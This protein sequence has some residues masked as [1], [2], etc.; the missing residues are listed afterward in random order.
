[1]GVF[2]GIQLPNINEGNLDDKKERKQI[3]NYLALLDEK[4]RY[5][6]QNIDI[7]ENLSEDSQKMFFKYGEDIRN[8]IK[9]T[10]GNFSLF[11]QTING[12]S[13]A[14]Q[15]VEGNTT[16]HYIV[17]GSEQIKQADPATYDN[18]GNIIPLSERFDPNK[19]DIR[20]S[21]RESGLDNIEKKYADKTDYLFLHESGDTVFVDNMV[22]K[23]E[24]RDRG[25]GTKI[26]EDI[27]AYADGEG[28]VIALTPTSEF[29]TKTKLTKWYKKHG[30][31]ENKG[32]NTDFRL[33][34]TMYR[35]PR[36]IK[37]SVR[38]SGEAE[39]RRE[40]ASLIA[41]NKHLQK[42][43]ENLKKQFKLTDGKSPDPK[44][45][46]RVAK[47][48]SSLRTSMRSRYETMYKN[49]VKNGDSEAQR[50]AKAGFMEFGGK[51]TT[52]DKYH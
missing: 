44:A 46:K 43:N 17:F 21:V 23:K 39:L 11:E 35:L 12:I 20:W 40:N 5:M 42:L 22:V 14:V 47:E 8:V 34:D 30:F 50:E 13:S 27:I 28:M 6:F 3:L 10:E 25:V 48:D 38:E 7:E 52:L 15:D 31:V 29:G 16:T 26:L 19:K 36:Q 37:F 51:E 41:E 32:K 4:L 18:D 49:A 24:Y 1:M 2:G 33:R 9:D 45:V